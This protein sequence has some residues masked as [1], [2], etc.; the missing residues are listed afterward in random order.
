MN[1]PIR[2]EI[3]LNMASDLYFLRD[4]NTD[5]LKD[6]VIFLDCHE[7]KR[8]GVDFP[9]LLASLPIMHNLHKCKFKNLQIGDLGQLIRLFPNMQH[10]TLKSC[11]DLG[12]IELQALTV[13]TQLTS[14]ELKRTN[15][16]SPMGLLLLC[17]RL[18][19]L[20]TIWCIV[21]AQ[22]QGHDLESFSQLLGR[23]ISIQ[24]F[25]SKKKKAAMS[26]ILMTE[27]GFVISC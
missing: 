20:C 13:C 24:E 14:L 8:H 4:R 12:E 9:A 19:R 15:N 7:G 6:S 22:L 26:L 3:D 17:E 21:C 1:V 16:V 27:A 5:F 18:P 10:L 23:E 25:D 2:R 11:E